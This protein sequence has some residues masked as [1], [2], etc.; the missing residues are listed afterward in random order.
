MVLNVSIDEPAVVG[1]TDVQR[2][3]HE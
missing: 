2:Q 1:E 3:L